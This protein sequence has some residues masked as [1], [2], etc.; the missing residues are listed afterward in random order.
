[1]KSNNLITSGKKSLTTGFLLSAFLLLTTANS[2]AQEPALLLQQSPVKGGSITPESGVHYFNLNTNITITALPEPGY[3]FIYWLG[4]V[5]NP[6]SNITVV[7]LDS[8]KIVIAVFEREEYEFLA[9]AVAGTTS[10]PTGG[11][12]TS[13]RDYSRAGFS[14]GG[15]GGGRR[16][17]EIPEPVTAALIL[18]GGIF[19]FTH[20]Q[21]ENSKLLSKPTELLSKK[22]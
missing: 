5:S 4:D 1:M 18:V 2:Q 21:W 12:T 13:S 16:I 6:T 15:G 10:A 9:D 14:G 22:E 17:Q 8:P 3:R 19:V 7:N 20:K 11:L